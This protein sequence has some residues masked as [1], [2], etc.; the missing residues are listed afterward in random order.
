MYISCSNSILSITYPIGAYNNKN[1]LDNSVV[2]FAEWYVKHTA[3]S[4][5]E[6]YNQ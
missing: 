5:Q 4:T 3:Q 2:Q 6:P 1:A